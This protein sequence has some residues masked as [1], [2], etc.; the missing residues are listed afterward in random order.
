MTT[1]TRQPREPVW[2][3]NYEL[4]EEEPNEVIKIDATPD[5][6]AAAVTTYEPPIS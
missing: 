6:L 5:E 1:P 4:T 2:D 3:D